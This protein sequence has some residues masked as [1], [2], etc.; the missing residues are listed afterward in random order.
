MCICPGPS[1]VKAKRQERERRGEEREREEEAQRA[2][3]SMLCMLCYMATAGRWG[4]V[5]H[6]DKENGAQNVWEYKCE[7]KREAGDGIRLL[8]THH[9]SW[10][11]CC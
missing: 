5:E 2:S 7:E 6:R 3:Y 1:P 9:P 10:E 4:G 8:H 11:G